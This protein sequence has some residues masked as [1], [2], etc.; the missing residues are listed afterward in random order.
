MQTEKHETALTEE[1]LDQLLVLHAAFC[2]IFA[3]KKRLKIM[4]YL[5][6]D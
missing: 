6:G 2:S 3:D 1:E 5:R 4:W